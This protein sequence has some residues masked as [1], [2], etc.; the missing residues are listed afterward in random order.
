M[1]RLHAIADV[2]QGARDDHRHRVVEVRFAELFG[3]F[4][5]FNICHNKKFLC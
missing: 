4:P 5:W 3:Y 1:H 2:G